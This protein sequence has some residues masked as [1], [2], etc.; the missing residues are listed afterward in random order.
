MQV[1]DE[2]EDQFQLSKQQPLH[3]FPVQFPFIN[4]TGGGF[5]LGA[6]AHILYKR[7]LIPL[8]GT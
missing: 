7:D 3:R 2:S 4:G 1:F 5:L 6:I 8:N